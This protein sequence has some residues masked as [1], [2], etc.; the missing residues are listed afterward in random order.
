MSLEQVI[1]VFHISICLSSSIIT[2]VLTN[3]NHFQQDLK[4]AKLK[5]Y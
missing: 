1:R 3:N 5:L 4:E 2:S